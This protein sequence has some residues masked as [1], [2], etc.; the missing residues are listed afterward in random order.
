MDLYLVNEE[1]ELAYL[2]DQKKEIVNA[3]I[4][5]E[6]YEILNYEGL[7]KTGFGMSGALLNLTFIPY[8]YYDDN[9]EK[10]IVSKFQFNINLTI[11]K[12]QNDYLGF[13]NYDGS[14]ENIAWDYYENLFTI[15]YYVADNGDLIPLKFIDQGKTEWDG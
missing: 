13:V 11:T 7:L 8:D 9:L 1:V 3:I 6:T 12:E 4:K 2:D 14:T 15:Y 10:M 5:H